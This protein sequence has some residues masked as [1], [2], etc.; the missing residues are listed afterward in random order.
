[1]EQTI[2]T[3]YDRHTEACGPPPAVGNESPDGHV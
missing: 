1:M 2:L 3:I